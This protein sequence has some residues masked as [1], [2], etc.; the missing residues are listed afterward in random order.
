MNVKGRFIV[1]LLKLGRG[2]FPA[3]VHQLSQQG[4]VQLTAA[5]L[6]FAHICRKSYN[7]TT[8]CNLGIFYLLKT[9][10]CTYLSKIKKVRTT[11]LNSGLFIW[12]KINHVIKFPMTHI[13]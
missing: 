6:L 8:P 9:V 11:L 10:K 1:P 7:I 4:F 2:G 5:L 12:Y 13:T 3:P